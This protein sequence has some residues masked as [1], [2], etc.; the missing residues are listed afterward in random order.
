M[1]DLTFLMNVD[2]AGS[3]NQFYKLAKQFFVA[4]SSTVIDAPAKGQT[5]EGVFAKLKDL[6]VAQGTVNLVCHA[7]GFA[8]MQCPVTVASQTAGRTTMTVD[9]LRDA[10]AAKSPASPGPGVITDKTRIVIYGCDVGRS[11]EFLKMLSGLFGD[12]GELLA[13]RRMG[14][15][16]L[17]GSDVKYRQAQTWS[18]VRKAP[19]IPG[20]ASAPAEG[21]PAYRT[22]F[23]KDATDKFGSAAMA[24]EIGGDDRLKKILTDAASNATTTLGPGFF[25]EEGVDIFPTGSQTAAQAAASVKP[26]SNG[27]PVTSAA[28]SV[29]QV[30]DTTVVTKVSGTDAYPANPQKTKFSISVVILGRVM[31]EDVAIA[32]GAGYRRVTTSKGLAPSPGPKSTGGS[33]AGGGSGSGAGASNNQVQTLV[34]QLLADGAAQADVDALAAGIPQGDA[35]DGLLMDTPDDTSDI[36]DPVAPVFVRQEPA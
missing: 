2:P 4:A 5:L 3:P 8:S 15:F 31:D 36:G 32:E 21:W 25:L 22:T 26:I 12:P 13:P 18:L 33:G 17:E 6:K 29:A 30:D 27:D 9:D 28:A 19:L 7:S 24:A 10:L 11:L 34:D 23:V 1:P 16:R 35:T 14:V 20:G